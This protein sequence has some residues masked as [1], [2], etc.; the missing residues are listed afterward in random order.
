MK[1]FKKWEVLHYKHHELNISLSFEEVYTTCFR[2][3]VNV[4]QQHNGVETNV[5]NIEVT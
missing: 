5:K 4:M 2:R 1:R 3:H